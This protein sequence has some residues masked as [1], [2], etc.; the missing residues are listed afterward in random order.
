VHVQFVN[1]AE[2]QSFQVSDTLPYTS[3]LNTPF[4]NV[5]YFIWYSNQ[6][7]S[8][9]KGFPSTQCSHAFHICTIFETMT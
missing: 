6:M 4:T 1:L 8:H 3:P 9:I 7:Q 2:S 5:T